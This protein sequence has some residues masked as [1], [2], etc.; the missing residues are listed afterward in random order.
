MLCLRIQKLQHAADVAIDLRGEV[1]PTEET[2]AASEADAKVQCG[3][4]PQP[5]L[6]VEPVTSTKA[7]QGI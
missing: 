1:L 2:T 3:P 6:T 7:T 4:G 5:R